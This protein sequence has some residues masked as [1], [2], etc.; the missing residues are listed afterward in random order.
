MYNFEVP[1]TNA[2]SWVP[3]PYSLNA[4]VLLPT[5]EYVL[6]SA[7]LICTSAFLKIK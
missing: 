5:T 2:N 6:I 3:I 4:M 7:S 1:Y